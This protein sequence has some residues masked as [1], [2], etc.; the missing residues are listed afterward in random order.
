MF[1]QTMTLG[2][3]IFFAK[4]SLFLL[5]HRLFRIQKSIR[6]AIIFGII[7]SFLNFSS[8]LIVSAIF[9]TPKVGHPWDLAVAAKCSRGE[10]SV[11]VLGVGNLILDIYLLILPI[12]VIL[13]LKLSVKKKIGVFAIFMAGLL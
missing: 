10:A 2:P 6:Y 12:P 8:Q 4:L 11:V 5:Y 3:M 7:F 1:L 9:C 13:P